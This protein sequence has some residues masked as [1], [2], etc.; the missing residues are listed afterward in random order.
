MRQFNLETER[1][2]A[3]LQGAAK[4]AEAP[5][6]SRFDVLNRDLDPF[7]THFL[8][9]S[10]GTGKTFAIEHLV[11]R[12]LLESNAPL[13][14]DQILVMTFTRAATRELRG[15]I[16]RN[17]ILALSQLRSGDPQHDYLKAIME[18]GDEKVVKGIRLLEEALACF[19]SAQIFTIHG[20]CFRA[21]SEF[22]FEGGAA[23]KMSDPDEQQHVGLINEA[24]H[25]FLLGD[26]EHLSSGQVAQLWRY[27]ERNPERLKKRL[28]NLVCQ[29]KDIA[30]FP[31]FADSFQRWADALKTFPN[32]R[33]EEVQADLT[34]LS[35]GYKQMGNSRF[36]SQIEKLSHMLERKACSA[37]EFDQLVREKD[38]FLDKMEASNRKARTKVFDGQA[39]LHYPSLFEMIHRQLGPII[40]QARN[41][42][43]IFLGLARKCR[44]ES[45]LKLRSSELV[46]PDD[47]LQQMHQSLQRPAFVEKVRGRYQ[48]AIIDEFQD[49]DPFQW[50]IFQTLFVGHMRSLC[51][52]GDP[53]QSIY[54]FRNADLYTYLKA[55][56]CLGEKSRKYLDTNY[57]SMP[58]LVSA[59][60][61]LFTAEQIRGW[62]SLPHLGISL[63]VLP[64][65]PG[66]EAAPCCQGEGVYFFAAEASRSRKE[67]RWPSD[68]MEQHAFFPYIAQEIHEQKQGGS[69]NQFAVLVKDRYQA[70]RLWEFL[71][72]AQIPAVVRRSACLN[73]SD[74][75]FA[76]Q[77]L[78]EAICF[79]SDI[80]RLKK[81]LGGPLIGWD[82]RKLQGHLESPFLR[83]AKEKMLLLHDLMFQKG[84]APVFHE[85]LSFRW[86][87][88]LSV[89]EDLLSQGS[90]DL[91]CDLQQ[92]VEMITEKVWN[93]RLSKE[94]WLELFNELRLSSAEEEGQ[95][96]RRSYAEE[97]A[98][99][100]LT[101]HMS[102]GLEFDVVFALGV[103]SSPPVQNE[104]VIRDE[105]GGRIVP[106]EESDPACSAS[107]KESEAEQLRQLY[108]ALTRAKKRVYIP[109]A[110]DL[111]KS[112]VR[113]SPI[114]LYFMAA[115]LP[116][117]DFEHVEAYLN[118]IRE[119]APLFL[120]KVQLSDYANLQKVGLL[121]K[122]A[123]VVLIP[124]T[125]SLPS[126]PI[127]PIVSYSSLAK[128]V[129]G[130]LATQLG[131][132]D[133]SRGQGGLVED[134]QI[135]RKA[136]T[137]FNMPAG[138]QTG[139][140]F[141]S[142]MEKVFQ[143]GLHFFPQPKRIV[144][145]IE[146]QTVYTELEPW[147]NVLFEN[148]WDLLHL[149]LKGF[150][151]SQIPPSQML[152][153]MEFLF[154]YEKGFMKGF[155]D[156]VFEWG[157][158]YYLLDWKTNY[159]GPSIEDYSVQNLSS[160]M[161]Q[162]DYFLQAS[163]YTEAL[164]R[165]VK[166]FDKRPFSQCF[167]GVFYVFVRGKA[168][169]DLRVCR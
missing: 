15:R 88:D 61:R 122:T 135:A 31:S 162:H 8:E 158:K 142:I 6:L 10:A 149:P 97:D 168:V 150:S 64:V 89:A 101:M 139:L 73:E 82:C 164:K 35:S 136:P 44:Q 92:L 29:E 156:L 163:I 93:K 128:K 148:I 47:L 56:E 147:K 75:F 28:A 3:P 54:A 127:Q 50:D 103:A 87:G 76:L 43:Q 36:V 65:R 46:S 91:Y 117:F 134:A 102:K 52:V 19:D 53:K 1:Q 70:Q 45:K 105:Q 167:G 37:D 161:E 41:P 131:S 108:V 67:S 119:A 121:E 166:L 14:L 20:F 118:K 123:P 7:A 11:V 55:A 95:L 79:P 94:Q 66:K 154:P 32:V 146:K 12:L 157:G 126:F 99:Q 130:D 109:L 90:L 42:R 33:G 129:E 60:N 62:M 169:Y 104:I 155:A 17:V 9:A 5:L 110:F 48:A 85:F 80:S 27:F 159:L 58:A 133:E 141:H 39:V 59:L 16:R 144:D 25:S 160:S 77:E 38:F 72:E 57:R 40:R 24:V 120:S 132:Y 22:G 98:V 34:W 153:E 74:A 18:Q 113:P 96:K 151:L 111:K 145:L 106:L 78:V 107:Q 69:W 140:I 2:D 100:I 13:A 138:A 84:F 81:V 49:T 152:Q 51:L 116:S 71:K 143:N 137:A 68:A 112:G 86:S 165:Y 63:D 23:F 30:P 115:G 125:Q 114:E 124:P 26:Q 21:L 4:L 83:E